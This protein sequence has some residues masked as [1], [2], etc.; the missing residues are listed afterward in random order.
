MAQD[1]GD[2]RVAADGK[3]QDIYLDELEGADESGD[4]VGHRLDGV[5]RFA[6]RAGD[7]GIVKNDD[8]PILCKPV[9]QQGIGAVHPLPEVL[10]EDEG[11]SRVLA[12]TPVRMARRTS[13]DVLRGRGGVCVSH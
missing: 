13:L 9:Q 12:H 4:V 10:Q 3:P 6:T 8:R 5:G 1:K 7:A 11:H 2:R